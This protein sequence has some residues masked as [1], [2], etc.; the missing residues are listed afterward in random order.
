LLW[1]KSGQQSK[2]PRNPGSRYGV[3]PNVK[4]GTFKHR[5]LTPNP[6]LI[7]FPPLVVHGCFFSPAAN[8]TPAWVVAKVKM[9]NG[10]RP[11]L[12]SGLIA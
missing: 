4:P 7:Y 6:P 8:A 10:V 2:K 1:A 9:D 12:G 11:H 3:G 5:A